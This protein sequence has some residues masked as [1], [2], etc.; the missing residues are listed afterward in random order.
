MKK[1]N[2]LQKLKAICIAIGFFITLSASAEVPAFD[3]DKAA[4]TFSSSYTQTF[5]TAWDGTTFNAQWDAYPNA[6][7]AADLGADYLQF[8]FG[9]KRILRSKTT[10]TTPYIFSGVIDWSAFS[11]RGGMI[12]RAAAAGS[13]E[14]LQEPADTDPGFNR[15]GIAF[16]PTADGL[17]MIVQFTGAD[18]GY[19]PTLFTRINVPKPS[20]VTSLINDRGNLRIEDFG[21][22]IYIYYNGARYIRINLG[23]LSGS[24]YT[25]GTVYNSDMTNLG[26]FTAREVEAVGKVAVA[27]RDA[28]IRLVS[29]TVELPLAQ[30]VPGSPTSVVA[31]AQNGQ[32]SVAFTAPIDNGGSAI[33]DYTVTSNLGGFTA[34]G[35]ASPIIVTGL[36]NGTNYTF[37]VTARNS[38][39]SSSASSASNSATPSDFVAF[40]DNFDNGTLP[41]WTTV[42]GTWTNQGVNGQGTN[43]QIM[44]ND[45]I[46]INFIYEADLKMSSGIGQLT[47]R[48]NSDAS[49]GYN[50]ALGGGTIKLYTFP[51]VVLATPAYTFDTNTWYHL[52][53]VANGTSI[54]V[55]FNNSLTPVIDM[56]DATFSSGRFGMNA[57]A[58]SFEFDNVKAEPLPQLPGAP[59]SIVATSGNGQASVAFAAPVSDG[60]S[61]ILDYTVT[62]S[63][64]GFTSTGTTSPL[65]VTG[66]SNGTSYTFTVTARNNRDNGAVSIVSNAITPSIT[67]IGNNVSTQFRTYQV[68][69]AIVVDLNGLTGQQTVTVFD[70][71]GK[72]LLTRLAIGGENLTFSNALKT[73]AYLIKVQGL[74]KSIM[75]KLIVK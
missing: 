62:S 66:L 25:S 54:K 48:G 75:T 29:A 61:A 33:L 21:T 47:F 49:N 41:G 42:S 57:Y 40:N 63:P 20:G 26:S 37:T 52:K 9:A 45:I 32:V 7:T 11:N 10:Y 17:N 44:K 64:G 65:I 56:I 50:L 51:Y 12:I 18:L 30:S 58:G 53:I 23:G 6:F 74:E 60:G 13:L 27:C 36:S 28:E 1:I 5:N 15:E 73:G 2:K 70:I 38:K 22:S 46:G 34:T 59:T 39:G 43:G 55:Y 3:S 68:G 4:T 14:S 19:G 69:S 35:S 72:C 71:Q 67:S 24:I 8:V 31:T 16:Y